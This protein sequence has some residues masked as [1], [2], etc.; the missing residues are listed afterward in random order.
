MRFVVSVCWEGVR[1]RRH[2]RG[3]EQPFDGM[4]AGASHGTGTKLNERV[5][6]VRQPTRLDPK[7]YGKVKECARYLTKSLLFNTV[8]YFGI[9]VGVCTRITL[10]NE[11]IY[12]HSPAFLR[13][14]QERCRA[15]SRCGWVEGVNVPLL[16]RG[17]G[18]RVKF[19]VASCACSYVGHLTWQ[20]EKHIYLYIYIG[21]GL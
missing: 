13:V 8:Q 6:L 21:Y 10:Q 20:G 1:L 12:R 19:D 4:S 7:R 11:S 18:W 14:W 9:R 17:P 2:R 3:E 15:A 16:S 5:C